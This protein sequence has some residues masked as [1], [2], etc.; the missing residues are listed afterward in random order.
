MDAVINPKI[1]LPQKG[2]TLGVK[3]RAGNGTK[4]MSLPVFIRY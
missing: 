4:F 1:A 2:R 3:L